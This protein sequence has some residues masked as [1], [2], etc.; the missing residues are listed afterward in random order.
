MNQ[1]LIDTQVDPQIVA[2]RND[3][4]RLTSHDI[5][6]T[7]GVYML[8]NLDG[9]IK[10]V[11]Y[12]DKFDNKNDPHHEHDFGVI[13]WKGDTVFWKVDYFDSSLTYWCNP[14]KEDCRRVLT[15][16]LSSEY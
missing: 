2:I 8:A 3:I 15:I 11:R 4:F 13:K 16:M 12:Y 10:T 7:G 6:L 9:L 1:P 14:M 5:R